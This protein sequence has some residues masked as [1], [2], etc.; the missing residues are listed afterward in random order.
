MSVF[1]NNETSSYES[2]RFLLT[3]PDAARDSRM[4]RQT[5]K[6][7][8][9]FDMFAVKHKEGKLDMVMLWGLADGHSYLNNYPAGGRTDYP[10]LFDRE[11][12][13]KAAFWALVN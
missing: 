12:R 4:T 9:L 11:Y 3:L 8:E 10:L 5:E 2:G 13:P 6:Y 7:R 1:S